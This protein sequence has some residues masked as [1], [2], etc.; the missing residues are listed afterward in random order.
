MF[1][2]FSCQQQKPSQVG[3]EIYYIL[4]EALFLLDVISAF[5]IQSVEGQFLENLGND[6]RNQ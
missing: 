5:R 4:S 1:S 3:I 6:E 2:A